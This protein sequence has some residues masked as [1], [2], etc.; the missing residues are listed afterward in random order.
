MGKEA[1]KVVKTA[2]FE[3]PTGKDG[4]IVVVEYENAQSFH[5]NKRETIDEGNSAIC[6]DC[7]KFPWGKRDI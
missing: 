4:T 1:P 2:T 3:C 5:C 6:V 7:D